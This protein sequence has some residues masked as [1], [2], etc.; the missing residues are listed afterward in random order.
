MSDLPRSYD[1]WRTSGP[2]EL[3]AECD[4]C[5]AEHAGEDW[6]CDYSHDPAVCADVY[7]ADW[8]DPE[9][10]DLADRTTE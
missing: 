1:A 7:R 6:A 2:A 5:E 9:Y 8:C 3:P 4:R 10:F